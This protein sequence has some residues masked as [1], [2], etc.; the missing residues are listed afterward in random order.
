MSKAKV[1]ITVWIDTGV[2]SAQYTLH[3]ELFFPDQ[4][5]SPHHNTV[6]Y[7]YIKNLGINRERAVKEAREYLQSHSSWEN[8]TLI[9]NID[10]DF[11]LN[12]YNDLSVWQHRAIENIKH[13]DRFPFGKHQGKVIADADPNTIVWWS[14]QVPREAVA[15][16]LIERCIDLGN[17]RGYFIVRDYIYK[18]WAILIAY[19]PPSNYLGEEGERIQ[20]SGELVFYKWFENDWGGSAVN[21]IKDADGNL[22]VYFG[23]SNL[24]DKGDQVE[25]F[26]K[27]K[28]HEE[29]REQKQ[30]VVQ[31]P[32]KIKIQ[33]A[34]AA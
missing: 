29:Y 33:K 14:E 2:K 9:D 22:I 31:R 25:F 11:N 15:K 5:T 12:Q 26:A 34:V 7:T 21:K 23:T 20:F 8:A 28:K 19:Q 13:G 4:P 3:R 27:V 18:G 24:G 10:A 32:T 6:R 30:T 1:V 17:E 16:A